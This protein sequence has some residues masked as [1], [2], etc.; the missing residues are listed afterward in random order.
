MAALPLVSHSS[1]ARCLK[2]LSY[3][4]RDFLVWITGSFIDV[5]LFIIAGY[6]CPSNRRNPP[7]D[8]RSEVLRRVSG[9]VPAEP[10]RGWGGQGEGSRESSGE[11]N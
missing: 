6:L 7:S 2:A 10:A 9:E 8:R 1:T 4:V 5:L 11:M 3:L